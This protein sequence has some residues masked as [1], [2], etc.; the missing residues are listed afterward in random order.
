MTDS[1]GTIVWAADY[2]PFGEASI[3]VSTITNNQRG[4]GQYFDAETGLLYNYTRDLNP[5]IGRYIEN[6]RIGLRGGINLY[7]FVENN[8]LRYTDSRGTS[9]S[10]FLQKFIHV[11]HVYDMYKLIKWIV[12]G[13]LSRDDEYIGSDRERNDLFKQID[14]L[15]PDVQET[16]RRLDELIKDLEMRKQWERDNGLRPPCK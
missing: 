13:E 3:T 5:A 16:S 7:A 10:S 15:E 11:W 9:A 2:K 1:A 12:Y 4:I 8:P 6:D 14:Q